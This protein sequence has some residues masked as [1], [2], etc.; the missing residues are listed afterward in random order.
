MARFANPLF[1]LLKAFIIIRRI[2][3]LKTENVDSKSSNFFLYMCYALIFC[4]VLVFVY[5]L[6]FVYANTFGIYHTW[7]KCY[8][9]KT[10][11]ICTICTQSVRCSNEPMNN[12]S[13]VIV[14]YRWFTGLRALM[15]F[16]LTGGL[17]NIICPFNDAKSLEKRKQRLYM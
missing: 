13:T 7:S 6:C 9:S 14:S 3:I 8:S 15:N 12:I 17:T 10:C 4:S 16:E 2:M 5:F 1:I 11:V